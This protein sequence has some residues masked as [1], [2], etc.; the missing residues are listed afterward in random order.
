MAEINW[1]IVTY[2]VVGVFALAGFYRG[3][4][5]EA[6]TTFLLVI[7]IFLLKVPGVAQWLVDRL[8]NLLTAIQAFLPASVISL[9]QDVFGLSTTGGVIQANSA[10]PGTWLLILL[11]FVLFAV[12]VSIFSLPG[13]PDLDSKEDYFYELRPIGSVLGG[14]VGG[15]NGFIVVNLIRE[16]LDGR[17]LPGGQASTPTEI[18]TT[19]SVALP[20]VTAQATTLPSFTILDGP[21]PWIFMAVG[22]LIFIAAIKNRYYIHKD[23]NGFRKFYFLPPY[24][25]RKWKYEKEKKPEM[26]VELKSS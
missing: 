18:A 24:G 25:Y 8:N 6:F 2:L 12:L 21:L 11:L 16:Y 7:L 14:L 20:G 10:E 3:W 26:V 22:L 9:L 4:W 23:K 17:N 15:V 1:T 19:G 5:K 13:Q